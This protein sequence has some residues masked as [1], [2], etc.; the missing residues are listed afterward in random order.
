MAFHLVKWGMRQRS[1][2]FHLNEKFLTF[3]RK[4][5]ASTAKI[6]YDIRSAFNFCGLT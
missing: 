3:F 1:P 6:G 2:F 4:P 5:L